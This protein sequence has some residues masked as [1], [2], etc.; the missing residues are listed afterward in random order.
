MAHHRYPR[1]R[2]ADYGARGDA[3]FAADDAALGASRGAHLLHRGHGRMPRRSRPAG[4]LGRRDRAEHGCGAPRCR[5]ADSADADGAW[6][7]CLR[8]RGGWWCG[9]IFRAEGCCSGRGTLQL[10]L[11]RSRAWWRSFRQALLDG[12]VPLWRGGRLGG[13]AQLDNVRVPRG[14]FLLELAHAHGV[15]LRPRRFDLPLRIA[16]SCELDGG[17][18]T[19]NL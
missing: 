19:E 2:R 12:G 9:A 3:W 14:E 4:S 18:Q 15:P 17:P 1:R 6:S 5:P 10:W 11:G 8:E 16:H 13:L 7:A